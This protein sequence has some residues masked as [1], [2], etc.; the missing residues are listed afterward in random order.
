[1]DIEKSAEDWKKE[2]NKAFTAKKYEEAVRCY[3]E[4]IKIDPQD[5]SFFS[6]RA[7]SHYHLGQYLQ[8]I[9]DCE[10]CVSIKKNFTKAMRRKAMACHQI[11]RFSDAVSTLKVALEYEKTLD[12]KNEL[13]EA[14]HYLSNYERYQAAVEAGDFKEALSCINYLSNKIASN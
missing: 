2:G 12:V 9:S 14:E 7:T 3:T 8:C 11:L 5:H 10:T 6:N 4:A 13:E 1:M